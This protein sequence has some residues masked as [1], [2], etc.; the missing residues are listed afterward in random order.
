M[1]GDTLEY[2]VEH[3]IMPPNAVV[4]EL[5]R[6]LPGLRISPDGT[7]TYNGEKIQHLL[8][9]GED[10]FGSDPTMV[11]RN[12]DASKIARVQILDRKSE[13]TLF[14]G[15]DDGSRTKTLNLVMRDSAKNGYFGKIEGGG[16][17]NGDFTTN[18][19]LAGFRRKEQ[20]TAIGLASNTGITGT[21]SGAPGVSFLDGNADALGASAGKGIPKFAATALHYANTWNG[22]Q[23]HLTANYQYSHYYTEPATTTQSYQVQAD[24]IYGQNQRSNSVN[25][26]NQHWMYGIY[27]L[28]S[29]PSSAL[30]L[31][32]HISNSEGQNQFGATGNSTFNDT[33]VNM[34]L[35]TINDRVSRENIGGGISW[36]TQIGNHPGRIISLGT[37]MTK[38]D[39]ITN[40]YL[41]SFEQFYQPGGAIQSV[42]TVD[43]RKQMAN[44]SMTLV[45]EVN[46]VEPLWKGSALGFGYRF[47]TT[48]DNPLQE[49]FDR[50]DGKYEVMV[51]SLSN[52]YQT[53]E[54]SQR[55]SLGLQGKSGHLSYMA[56]NGW[57]I[58]NYRQQDLIADSATR[59][60]Y[61]NW[62]PRVLIN[63]TMDPSTRFVFNYNTI[64]QQPTILQ[65]TPA[66]N[67]SD[68]LH[69]AIGN[70]RLKPGFSQTFRLDAERFKTWFVNIS[71]DLTLTNNSICS[72]TITDSLGRQ[73]SQPVN[74]NGGGS[75]GINFSINRKILG[76]D[77]GLHTSASFSRTITYVNADLSNN[78]VYTGG[79]G[80]TL[81]KYVPDKYTIEVSTNVSYFNQISSINISTPTH[82]WTQSHQIY[83]TIFFIKHF[84]INT[85][86]IYTWQQRTSAFPS[87]TSVLLWNTYASRNILHNKLIIKAQFNNIFNQNAGI[88]RTN[89]GNINAQS[90]TNILGRYWILSAIYHFD[91]SFKKR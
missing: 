29:G 21:G 74:V 37:N 91:R 32:F 61:F 64:T 56:G 72:R 10:I 51:D 62:L 55:V 53:R 25:Q 80:F 43:Q 47:A 11:T 57:V 87:G 82:Y 7:I 49:T 9:D 13:Q 70:P 22:T 75:G 4:E 20:F 26:Q 36:R 42:D 71:F 19:A 85:N 1:K 90:S 65:L 6:R 76:F 38:V 3:T 83:A 86:A 84:E 50:G 39:A 24:S 12:F 14:T 81:N 8:V 89:S 48:G 45:G 54:I 17:S 44:H 23:D 69:I 46:Y 18:G 88:T 52:H 30:K 60:H 27:D 34:S 78:N 41:R 35:R 40:G 16:N 31:T 73:I 77:A 2:N 28:A 5:L 33:V 15:V 63:Y 79:G 59:V 66:I 58:Y 68:P 67:N